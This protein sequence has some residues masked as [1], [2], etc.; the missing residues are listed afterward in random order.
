MKLNLTPLFLLHGYSRS[1]LC[2]P[3]LEQV[4]EVVKLGKRRQ[5]KSD[6]LVFLSGRH[7]LDNHKKK[8]NT[9]SHLV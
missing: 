1:E 9:E 6:T 4:I 7:E 8:I 5:I 2:V 3:I